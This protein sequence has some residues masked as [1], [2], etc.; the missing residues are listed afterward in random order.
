MCALGLQ[1]AVER[2]RARAALGETGGWRE[3]LSGPSE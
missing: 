3:A 1:G 2:E